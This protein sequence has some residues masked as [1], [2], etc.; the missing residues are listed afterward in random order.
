MDESRFITK[1]LDI[2]LSLKTFAIYFLRYEQGPEIWIAYISLISIL[3]SPIVTIMFL[4]YYAIIDISIQTL[5]QLHW[6]SPIR[7]NSNLECILTKHSFIHQLSLQHCL[8]ITISQLSTF[9]VFYS[10]TDFFKLVLIHIWA[11]GAPLFCQYRC[12]LIWFHVS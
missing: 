12:G 9:L 1:S 5:L 4:S 11:K 6:W 3:L 2:N 7:T 8:L 10:V